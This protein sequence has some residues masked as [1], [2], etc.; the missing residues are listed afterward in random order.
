MSSKRRVASPNKGGHASMTVGSKSSSRFPPTTQARRHVSDEP[1]QEKPVT[2]PNTWRSPTHH[3]PTV[4]HAGRTPV[5][6]TS[7][8]LPF[9]FCHHE[10]KLPAS[11]PYARTGATRSFST[12]P[13][14]EMS[15]R[16][17]RPIGKQVSASLYFTPASL[18]QARPNSPRTEVCAQRVQIYFYTYT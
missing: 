6:T 4:I 18:E 3:F 10:I 15:T 8:G 12:A 9:D 13:P 1:P 14:A 5:N 7:V 2:A 16:G 17:V 11:L